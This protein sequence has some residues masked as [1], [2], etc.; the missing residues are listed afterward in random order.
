M[1]DAGTIQVLPLY[2]QRGLSHEVQLEALHAMYNMCKISPPRQEA[3][4]VAGIVPLLVKLAAPVPPEAPSTSHSSAQ[5]TG[6]LLLTCVLLSNCNHAFGYA[7]YSSVMQTASN[8]APP[9]PC[10]ARTGLEA[11]HTAF[12]LKCTS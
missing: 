7:A 2:L 4:A 3:A 5:S 6:K 12:V 10:V 8:T 9:M 11:K 1:Q